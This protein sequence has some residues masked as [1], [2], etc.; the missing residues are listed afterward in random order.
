MK[1]SLLPISLA[2]CALALPTASPA[3]TVT[4]EPD[5]FLE[6]VET[7][8]D[9]SNS[10]TVTQYID[11]GVKAE[12]GLKARMDA[13]ILSTTRSDSAIL[14]ARKGSDNRF[15][16]LHSNNKNAFAAYGYGGTGKW[17]DSEKHPMGKRF[18]EVA[19][20][21]DGTAIQIYINGQPRVSQAQQATIQSVAEDPATGSISAAWMNN[22]TLYLFAGNSDGTAA[23]PCRIRLYELKILKKNITTGKFDLLRHYLPCIKNGRA[24]LYDKEHGTISYSDGSADLVAGPVLDKPLDFVKWIWGNNKQWFDTWVWGKSG[25]KSEVDVGVRDYDGDRAIL[26]SRGSSGNTRLYM[27]YH[28]ESAFRFAHGTLPATNIINVVAP[29]NDYYSGARLDTRYLIKA[30]MT[31]GNQSM[32]VSRNGGTAT[33][34]F[35]ENVDYGSTFSTYLATTNTLYLLANH[36]YGTMTCSTKCLVYATK[37]WDGDE[38]LRDFVP[39]V[40]TNSSGVAYAG[41]YDT[42]SER[43]FRQI[44]TEEFDLSS[45]VGGVTNTLRAAATDRPKTRIEYIESDGYY[46]YVDLGVTGKDGVEMETTMEWKY[47][48]N[49]RSFCGARTT[50]GNPH[51][52]VSGGSAKGG[53]MRFFPYHYWSSAHRVGYDEDLFSFDAGSATAGIKYRVVTRLDRGRGDTSVSTFL[54]G[55]WSAP[56]TRTILPGNGWD[57]PIDTGLPLYLFATND[58]DLP[59][60]NS[61]TRCYGFKLRVKQTDGSYELVRDLVPVKDPATGNPIFWDRVSETYFRNA[62]KYLFAGGG[63]EREFEGAFVLVV[64]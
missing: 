3:M 52:Q 45:Q 15:L 10:A 55:S 29:T 40:A 34:L 58:D 54:N 37:I 33:P 41:L 7:N 60:Y 18:E 47:V 19:D 50:P 16:M 12:T 1:T 21:S 9:S 14:G 44:G 42:V 61:D 27:A 8:Q 62:G 5:A 20:F 11:T 23:W 2:L 43:I 4:A 28:H 48:P 63:A 13:V 32:T 31:V 49:D 6:Y 51:I 30:D 17:N 35:K 56:T 64:R 57:G 46:D 22:L 36:R 53:T 38:L 25:L 59:R 24:G 39:V 26:A